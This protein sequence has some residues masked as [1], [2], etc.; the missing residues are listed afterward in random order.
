MSFIEGSLT[1]KTNFS[2]NGQQIVAD[3]AALNTCRFEFSGTYNFSGIFEA[4][5]D[6]TNGTDGTWFPFDVAAV[7]SPTTA[8]SHSTV[9]GVQAYEASCHSV[10]M[11]RFRLT[12][13]T[14]AATH[15]VAIGGNN[16]AIEPSPRVQLAGSPI[17][18]SP[19]GTPFVVNST[20]GSN[21][22]SVKAS[23]GNLFEVQI[24]NPTAT[25]IYVKL[26][27]KASAPVVASDVPVVT[28]PV[29]AN[30]SIQRVYGQNGK[31]F[32]VGIALAATGAIGDTDATAAVVGVHIHG[33]YV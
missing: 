4:S 3:V 6:S 7:N 33:T 30:S 20:A 17:V 14:S 22:T 10:K 18:S 1:T 15:R 23:A 27:N 31:R 32:S 11:V 19:A 9:N 21:L 12:A 16:A 26:Y 28:E 24:S 2:A 29:P 13:F 5:M 25:P 8:T